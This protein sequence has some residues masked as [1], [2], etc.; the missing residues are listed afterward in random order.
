M[1]EGLLSARPIPGLDS[2]TARRGS[3]YVTQPML[4]DD[5]RIRTGG[6]ICA[7]GTFSVHQVCDTYNPLV[8]TRPCLPKR[9]PRPARSPDTANRSVREAAGDTTGGPHTGDREARAEPS[10]ALGQV[11]RAGPRAGSIT[12]RGRLYHCP[13]FES[14]SGAEILT[15]AV[16]AL[17]VFG[18]GR[19]PDIARTIGRHLRELKAAVTDLRQ[20]IEQEIGPLRDPIKEIKEDLSKPVSD[21]R[22]TL[23]ETADVAKSAER[24]I[25]RSAK[26]PLAGATGAAA[27]TG[28]TPPQATGSKD[29]AGAIGAAAAT[30][31]TPPQA[32]G[33][34]DAA[35]TI[36]AAA[37]TGGTPP[38]ATGS[39]DAAGA[40][41]AAAATGGTPPQA[42]GSKQ[43]AGAIGAAATGT[44]TPQAR[45]IAPDPPTGVSPS[46]VWE[47]MGDPMPESVHPPPPADPPPDGE[48]A[49]QA[50]DGAD[51]TPPEDSVAEQDGS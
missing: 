6:D 36:G 18:P 24:D 7:C 23:T 27:A 47:G 21:V 16:I 39:K 10:G 49:G 44:K 9:P 43:A 3:P 8:L 46:E 12:P 29:A 50:S 32:T 31:G 19:L 26:G 35:G 11:T 5:H 20:G 38:Q 42:T 25:R 33:S 1:T 17:V 40:I 13:M 48:G 30:G 22:R 51:E 34:K 15:I 45:W 28:G 14:L 2:Y 41:G 4:D 37:A